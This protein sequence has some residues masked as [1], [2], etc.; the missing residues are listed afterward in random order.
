VVSL[1]LG[2]FMGGWP[3]NTYSLPYYAIVQVHPKLIAQLGFASTYTGTNEISWPNGYSS[4]ILWSSS[5]GSYMTVDNNGL[6]TWSDTYG[7]ATIS[8]TCEGVTAS[9]Y[10]ES[11]RTGKNGQIAQL[12]IKIINKN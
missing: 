6:V 11:V 10:S 3:E 2:G 7:N 8:A 4:D 5:N 9:M 12:Q 1:Q